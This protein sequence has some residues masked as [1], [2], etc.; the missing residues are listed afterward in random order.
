MDSLT[1]YRTILDLVMSSH[2]RFHDIRCLMTFVWAIVGLICEK[3]VTLSKWS[4][5]RLSASRAASKQRQ[6][7][8]WLRNPKI[9]VAAIYPKLV[10]KALLGWSGEMV[11]LALDSSSL[12]DRFV[13]VRVALIYRGRAVPLSW[14]VLGQASTSVAFE[15][16]KPI[17]KDAARCLPT[18][19][20]VIL[21]ADRGFDDIDLMRQARDLGWSFRIRLKGSLWVYRAN[22]PALKVS[23]LMPAKG[24]ALFIQKVWLTGRFFGPVYLALAQV[25]TANGVEFWAIVSDA[26]T[27]LHTFDEYGLRFDLEEDFLDDKSAGF[28]IEASEI[29][30][31]DMLARLGLVL[32]TTTLYLVSTGT[33]V[34][35]QGWR[36][37]VDPHWQRGLSYLQIG[38]RWV[39]HALVNSKPLLACFRLP[40]G[41]DPEPVYASK[42]QAATP[43]AILFCL[44]EEVT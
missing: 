28:Q 24:Q 42:A 21:L 27:G 3:T 40:P 15:T 36:T 13:I 41:P 29:R 17:L 39:E 11:Y 1:L 43:I 12:W 6:F 10:Q 44:L 26:P 37:W 33:Q 8:R 31:A 2:V 22:K 34:V 30:D 25:Y 9:Q 4:N 18:G 23:R 19:C 32:A 7:V 35:E 5:H 14:L 16:Y 38:W 20:R